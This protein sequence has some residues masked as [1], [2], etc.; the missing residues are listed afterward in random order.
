MRAVTRSGLI[1][2][3]ISSEKEQ[4]AHQANDHPE[5]GV[6]V[7]HQ[8]LH[9]ADDEVWQEGQLTLQGKTHETQKTR[10]A[11]MRALMGGDVCDMKGQASGTKTRGWS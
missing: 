2:D 7:T 3:L 6:R 4:H 10:K 9:L 11:S 8:F 5:P 1:G